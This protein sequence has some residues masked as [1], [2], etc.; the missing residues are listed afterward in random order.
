MKT[1]IWILSIVTALL[2]VLS[3]WQY[4]KIQQ[5]SPAT[6]GSNGTGGNGDGSASFENQLEATKRAIKDLEIK[7]TFNS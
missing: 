1:T 4:R 2:I 5:L 7:A 6:P 3:L